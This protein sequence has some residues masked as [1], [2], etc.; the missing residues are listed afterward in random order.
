[1]AIAIVL[2]IHTPHYNGYRHRATNTHT[3][4][5]WPSPSCY[6]YTP[7]TTMAIAIVLQI[8]TPCYKYTH[9]TTTNTH[10]ALLQIHTPHYNGYRHRATNTH[11]ALQW[12]SPSC[13]KY[14]PRTTNTHTALQWLSP[15]HYK[16]TPRTTNTLPAHLIAPESLGGKTCLQILNAPED[17][18]SIRYDEN[19]SHLHEVVQYRENA[20][21]Y[22]MF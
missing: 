12:L 21:L 8:H 14:T 4:L 22:A 13:Y 17:L 11:T 2:Q 10:T 9:R 18:K 6:K 3:A 1:M 19:A 5:Q 20:S 16:Y 15:S 7:R